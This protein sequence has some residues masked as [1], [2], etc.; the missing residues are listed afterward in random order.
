[1]ADTPEKKYDDFVFVTPETAT[2][3]QRTK[4]VLGVDIK[5]NV[6]G[7]G[8]QADVTGKTNVKIGKEN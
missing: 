5:N 3:A 8:N 6:F 1:M 4:T 7:G 2:E